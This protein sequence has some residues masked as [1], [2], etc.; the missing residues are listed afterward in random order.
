MAVAMYILI[1]K[2]ERKI[3]K[4]HELIKENK[5]SIGKNHA[6]LDEHNNH[7]EQMW[8][9]IPKVDEDQDD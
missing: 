6:R 5:E 3:D 7:I 1:Y 9:T 4:L 8:V 2:Y